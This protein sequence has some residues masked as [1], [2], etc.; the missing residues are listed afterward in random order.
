MYFIY[1]TILTIIE[2]ERGDNMLISLV[3]KSG[4]GKSTIARLLTELDENVIHIDVDKISHYVLTLPEVKKRLENEMSPECVV[5]GVVDRKKVGSIVFSSPAKMDLLTDITWPNMEVII[6]N[7]L[8]ENEGKIIILDW[9][10]LPKTKFFDESNLRI[11]VE[12]PVEERFNR[13]L[14]RAKNKEH[15]TRDYF[16]KRDASGID[17]EEGKYEVII[18]NGQFTDLT[19]EVKKVYEKSIRSR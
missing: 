5:D 10:L 18:E 19:K 13:V 2:L 17:Y 7:L 12:T 9:L 8:Q 15:I 14:S 4:S 6:T 11:W 3:G 1:K 16:L